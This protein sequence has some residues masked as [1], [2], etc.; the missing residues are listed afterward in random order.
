MKMQAYCFYE[1]EDTS[2]LL[3]YEIED[4]SILLVYEV[5]DTSVVLAYAD[6]SVLLV[7]NTC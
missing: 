6:T 2:I 1:V 7:R 4:T 5:E 3:V